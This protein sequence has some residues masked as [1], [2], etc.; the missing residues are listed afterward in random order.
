MQQGAALSSSQLI[1]LL[2]RGKS[3]KLSAEPLIDY[4][5]PL[6]AWLDQQIRYEPVV[7]WNSNLADVALFQY[8][9]AASVSFNFA[10]G[11]IVFCT[12]FFYLIS[13]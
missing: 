1:R 11:L 10:F 9:S 5:R 12:Q 2:T 13:F 8:T 6:E 7:G 4:F 3:S